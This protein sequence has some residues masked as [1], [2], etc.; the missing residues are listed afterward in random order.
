MGCNLKLG[1]FIT[2][3]SYLYGG[4]GYKA[5][6]RIETVMN[7]KTTVSYRNCNIKD[8]TEVCVVAYL[9][10]NMRRGIDE[11]KVYLCE[12][13]VDGISTLHLVGCD[14]D[15]TFF[16][17]ADTSDDELCWTEMTRMFYGNIQGNRHI[18][19]VMEEIII[20]LNE[21][22]P[23]EVSKVREVFTKAYRYDATKQED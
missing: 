1:S 23:K 6:V 15:G 8:E 17:G 22:A 2:P 4:R 13:Y 18:W 7:G 16:I 3:R 12:E 14:G 20:A 10:N 19:D 5:G 21:K 11:C 9:G